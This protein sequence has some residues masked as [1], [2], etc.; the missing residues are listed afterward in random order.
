MVLKLAG[1][2]LLRGLLMLA[3]FTISA[4]S[5]A[6][7]GEWIDVHVHPMGDKGNAET[8]DQVGQTMVDIMNGSN[9]KAMVIMPPPGPK[10]RL[11]LTDEY[12]AIR[13]KYGP[14]FAFMVGGS[15]NGMLVNTTKSGMVT[16]EVRQRFKAFAEAQIANGA[17]GFGEIT[18]LH[19]SH[20]P[21]HPFLEVS[22]DH[23]LML[24]LADIAARH[25]VPIDLHCDPLPEDMAT[26]SELYS[27]LNPP[28]LKGNLAAMERLLAHNRK[29]KIVWAHLGS[30]P[31]GFLPP[32]VARNFLERHPN[33]YFS[34]RPAVGNKTDY[35][36]QGKSL[37]K[38][39]LPVLEQFPD[40]FVIGTDSFIIA[41]NFTGNDALRTLGMAGDKTRE[42]VFNLLNDLPE[43]LAIK[44][45]Y[46]NAIRIYKLNPGAR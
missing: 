9:M 24:L 33:L 23:P 37:D 18:G 10:A 43:D 22:P 3:L 6:A 46:E 29:A 25:D 32:Q 4:S 28:Q 40:R 31:M 12:N 27:K 16:D 20:T 17:I 38:S 19:V 14:R 45:G 36:L 30:H 2:K 21:T 1:G 42:A 15:L 7:K 41:H 35:I 5:Q 8:F 34:I 39:W 13:A 26:P 44:I 11:D